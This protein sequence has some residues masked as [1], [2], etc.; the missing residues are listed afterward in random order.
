M[1]RTIVYIDGFNLYYGLLRGTFAKWLDLVAFSKAL[2]SA[3]VLFLLNREKVNHRIEVRDSRSQFEFNGMA[4]PSQVSLAKLHHESRSPR[5]LACLRN[6]FGC[7]PTL[8]R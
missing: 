7:K 2:L 3:L 1:K 5:S 4:N 8:R 6:Q